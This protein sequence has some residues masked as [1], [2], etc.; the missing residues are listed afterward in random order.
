VLKLF[1]LMEGDFSVPVKEATAGDL[2]YLDPP[3]DKTFTQYSGTKFAGASTDRL[4]AEL[5]EAHDRG[6][7]FILHNSDTEKVQ[8]WFGD[9]AKVLKV[10][11]KRSVSAAGD[12]REAAPCVLVSNVPEL[13][14]LAS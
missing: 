1:S 10:N 4:G 12:K 2:I 3:Y 11:E 8:Y 6:A 9:Y 14:E 7:A 13:L 5:K